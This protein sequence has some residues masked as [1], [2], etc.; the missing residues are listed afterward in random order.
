M[1][2]KTSCVERPASPL[3]TAP[4]LI[5]ALRNH[6]YGMNASSVQRSVPSG[7]NAAATEATALHCIGGFVLEIAYGLNRTTGDLDFLCAEPP[8]QAEFIERR[9][10]LV[11]HPQALGH[12][13][14]S[15]IVRHRRKLLAPRAQIFQ[16]GLVNRDALPR[17]RLSSSVISEILSPGLSS[18]S[19]MMSLEMESLTPGRMVSIEITPC[20]CYRSM[21][22]KYFWTV[23]WKRES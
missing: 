15:P 8:A 9:R 17:L 22:L 12:Q 6:A 7:T 19:L 18:R 3:K 16:E 10:T 23:S 5:S 14:Q 20:R 13:E 2:S 21:S 4:R 11:F 1:T